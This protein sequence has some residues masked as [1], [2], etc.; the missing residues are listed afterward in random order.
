MPDEHPLVKLG[1]ERFA[2]PKEAVIRF[3]E[4][5]AANAQLND[6]DHFPHMFVLACCMDRQI[7]AERAWMIPHRVGQ[8]LG[9][10]DIERLAAPTL[11]EYKALFAAEKLHRYN[12]LMAE[13]FYGVVRRIVD[14]YGGDAARIW[15]DRPGSAAVVS[16][17][18]EF[19]G[20]G[21]KIATMAANLLARQFKIPF[22]DYRSIDVSPDVHVKRVMARMGLVPENPDE[23]AVIY[24]AR[25]LCPD[26]PGIIDF[27][28]WEI[29]REY[30][31]ADKQNC[32]T[33]PAREGCTTGRSA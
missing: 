13:V 25:E 28:L 27:S 10:F 11:E 1:R 7:M 24:A 15:S 6:L 21:I 31:K 26:F 4:D 22:A 3:V 8:K 19:K 33:C 9:G 29:G 16:R 30:C 23:N 12:D 17:F 5:E 20:V 18:L 2:G 32:A 14:Q